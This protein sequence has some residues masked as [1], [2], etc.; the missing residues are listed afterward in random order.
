MPS[1]RI[2]Q[3][4]YFAELG[5]KPRLYYPDEIYKSATLT[6]EKAPPYFTLIGGAAQVAEAPKAPETKIPEG[7]PADLEMSYQ[8]MKTFV[9][10]NGIKVADY[11]KDTMLAAIAQFKKESEGTPAEEGEGS[12][13]AGDKDDGTEGTPAELPE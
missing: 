6:P 3:K 13:E 7:T 1:Y 4:C 5:G 8:E 9:S 10:D 12:S 2:R 11:K